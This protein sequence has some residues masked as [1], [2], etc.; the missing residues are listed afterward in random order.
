M[1]KVGQ[2]RRSSHTRTQDPRSV[3]DRGPIKRSAVGQGSGAGGK[4]SSSGKAR[5]EEERK[6]IDNRASQAGCALAPT[7][8]RPHARPRPHITISARLNSATRRSTITTTIS[9][10]IPFPP[11]AHPSSPHLTHVTSDETFCRQQCRGIHAVEASDWWR[12]I[13][14]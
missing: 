3:G 4:G 11:P 2:A 14:R 5:R 9:R 12:L 1:T 8:A 7:D 6:R 10:L 13:I